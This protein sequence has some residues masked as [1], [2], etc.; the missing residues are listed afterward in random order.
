[1]ATSSAMIQVE[2]QNL[3]NGCADSILEALQQRWVAREPAQVTRE[4]VHIWELK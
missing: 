3:K 4:R 1:M 2:T